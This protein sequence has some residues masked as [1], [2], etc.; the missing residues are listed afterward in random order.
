MRTSNNNQND[1]PAVLWDSNYG[2]WDK[3]RSFTIPMTFL[4]AFQDLSYDL[5]MIPMMPAEPWQGMINGI[6]VDPAVRFLDTL[7]NPADGWF[8]IDRIAIY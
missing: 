1:D 4:F 3:N 2:S 8:E 6:R 7:G 5:T